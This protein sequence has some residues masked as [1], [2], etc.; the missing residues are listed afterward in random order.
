[1]RWRPIIT[2][3]LTCAAVAAI[4]LWVRDA[5]QVGH[6]LQVHTGTNNESGVYYGF[7]SGLTDTPRD[8]I[9]SNLAVWGTSL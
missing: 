1:M 4:V 5:P 3:G 9:A 2:V 8:P 6:W 7:W